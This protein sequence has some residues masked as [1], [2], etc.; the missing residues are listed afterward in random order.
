MVGLALEMIS[1]F[2]RTSKSSYL[3]SFYIGNIMEVRKMPVWGI[4]ECLFKLLFKS[5]SN[6]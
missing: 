2:D 6:F 5:Q 4:I 1:G 3:I